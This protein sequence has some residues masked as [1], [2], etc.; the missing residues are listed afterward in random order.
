MDMTGS[1]VRRNSSS[2]A[3]GDLQ[4]AQLLLGA[5]DTGRA[6]AHVGVGSGN[7]VVDLR[8]DHS[9][10]VDAEQWLSGSDV[11]AGLLHVELLDEGVGA[12]RHGVQRVLVRLGDPRGTNGAHEL[13]LLGAL[14]AHAGAL[15]A[16][17]ADADGARAR[18]RGLVGIDRNVVH[19]HRVLLRHQRDVG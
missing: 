5:F 4:V 7:A 19:A 2:T 9:R 14:G 10:A 12:Q 11:G 13:A 6:G 15:H 1:P 18:R 16:I 3:L 8:A 17:E